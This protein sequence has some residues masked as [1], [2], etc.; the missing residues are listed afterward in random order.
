MSTEL[1][2]KKRRLY[3]QACLTCGK[4]FYARKDTGAV[5][6]SR[7][8]RYRRDSVVNRE[9]VS[10]WTCKKVFT[11]KKS[12]V[13]KALHGIHFCSRACKDFAQSIEGGCKEIRPGHYSNGKA[14]YRRRNRQRLSDGCVDCGEKRLW[15]LQVH[16]IDGD[17]MNNDHA[18]LEV[19]CSNDH[20]KRHLRFNGKRWLRDNRALTPREL[21]AS[22]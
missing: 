7:P 19:L 2:G 3:P 6:C 8:C 20:C 18:N 9:T 21:L 16:H 1:D 14:S 12:S 13:R 17:R 5:F 4:V 15:L 10:C 22:L 11:R